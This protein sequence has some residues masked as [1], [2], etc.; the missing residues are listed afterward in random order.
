MIKR[1]KNMNAEELIQVG[2]MFDKIDL[3]N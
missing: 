1:L 2:R 3:E